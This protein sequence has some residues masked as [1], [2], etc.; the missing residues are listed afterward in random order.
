MF[1]QITAQQI[2]NSVRGELLE[3]TEDKRK[4]ILLVSFLLLIPTLVRRRDEDTLSLMMFFTF[5][6][7]TLSRYYCSVW[8]MLFVLGQTSRDG[9]TRAPGLF[10]GSVL[11]FMAAAFYW[12]PDTG[13]SSLAASGPQY[14]FVNY[15]VYG[16]FVLL[17]VGY[18]FSD[19]RA[20]LKDRSDRPRLS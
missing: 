7:V 18:L 1:R 4:A 8:A 5:L 17:C 19:V 12:P 15:E 6:T 20:W 13:K 14:F 9:P 16:M 11:L 3:I 2:K 10:S